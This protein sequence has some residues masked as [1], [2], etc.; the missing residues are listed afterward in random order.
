MGTLGDRFRNTCG[1]LSNA[2][3]CPRDGCGRRVWLWEYGW[4]SRTVDR[5]GGSRKRSSCPRRPENLEPRARQERTERPYGWLHTLGSVRHYLWHGDYAPLHGPRDFVSLS[6]AIKDARRLCLL[7]FVDDY[8]DA[9]LTVHAKRVSA[10][11][12]PDHGD[13]LVDRIRWR[14]W[15]MARYT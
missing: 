1:S 11:M 7:L 13:S 4:G 12:A 5:S 9:L 15:A 3:G 2:V 14:S 8:L 10:E 6:L